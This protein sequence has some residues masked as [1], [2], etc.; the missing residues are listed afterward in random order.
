MP[1]A[2][3]AVTFH[4]Y[5]QRGWDKVTTMNLECIFF[6]TQRMPSLN[7]LAFPAG[8]SGLPGSEKG[9]PALLPKRKEMV[10]ELSDP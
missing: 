7:P 1:V 10:H 9:Q 4:E 6:L 3:W 2:D 5:P 8:K